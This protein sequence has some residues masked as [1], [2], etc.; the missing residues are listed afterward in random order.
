MTTRYHDIYNAAGKP[1]NSGNAFPNSMATILSNDLVDGTAW[2]LKN[3]G[4]ARIKLGRRFK[5]PADYVSNP[6]F[7]IA[8]I[9][10]TTTNDVRAFADYK[11]HTTTASYDPAA[12]DETLEATV[13]ANGTA[14]SGFEATMTPA[15]P[16][17]FVAGRICQVSLGRDKSDAADTH[18]ADVHVVG[19]WF[20]Y[21]DA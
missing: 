16:A 13:T 14:R 19:M 20:K 21:D 18:A 8:F 4:A 17:N 10:A 1:D 11:V 3:A 15:T 5:I 9:S 2:T 12:F 7:V 6:A